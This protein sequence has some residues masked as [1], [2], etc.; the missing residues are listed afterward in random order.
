MEFDNSN[1]K[2]NH[3]L[4]IGDIEILNPHSKKVKK[5]RHLCVKISITKII[6]FKKCC[7]FYNMR[8]KH[9]KDKMKQKMK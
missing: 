3:Q 9:W 6:S 2:T 8:L 5:Y 4:F 1:S 7:D